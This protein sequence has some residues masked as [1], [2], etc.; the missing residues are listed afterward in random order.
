MSAP[1][2]NRGRLEGFVDACLREA[3]RRTPEEARDFL[4]RNAGYVERHLRA[5]AAWAEHDDGHPRPAH[6]AGLSAFDLSDALDRLN[7]AAARR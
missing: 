2:P 7:A 3:D 5:A 1:H 6:L 4:K